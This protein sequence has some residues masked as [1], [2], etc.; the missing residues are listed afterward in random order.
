MY[1]S[2]KKI[3]VQKG[4]PMSENYNFYYLIYKVYHSAIIF[5]NEECQIM[6]IRIRSRIYGRNVYLILPWAGGSLFCLLVLFQK[7]NTFGSWFC[8]PLPSCL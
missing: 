1:T 2:I 5:G 8:L 6:R 7:D 3:M 4:H